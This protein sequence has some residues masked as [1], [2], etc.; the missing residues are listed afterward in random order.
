MAGVSERDYRRMLA[1]ATAAL[2]GLD[3]DAPWDGVRAALTDCF[4]GA[5]T[6]HLEGTPVV[7]GPAPLW[8]A[9]T[10]EE[11]P[12]GASV[13]VGVAGG[14]LAL[15]AVSGA[16]DWHRTRC[17]PQPCHLLIELPVTRASP[18]PP[19]ACAAP[20]PPGVPSSPQPPV[21]R[22]SLQ[23]PVIPASPQPPGVPSSPRPP[24]ARASLQLLGVLVTCRPDRPF[25]AADR[26]VARRLQP[27]LTSVQRHLAR[28]PPRLTEREL[29]VLA[30]TADG[31]TAVAAGRRL[32]ISPRTF[33][34]HLERLYRKFAT[35]DR[36]H[37]V[38]LAQDLGLLPGR[39]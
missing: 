29:A 2:G 18:Q 3:T 12:R 16:A 34:K 26:A 37:T 7:A 32:G 23:P 20:Q 31:L 35:R 1:V 28:R 19:V 17:G 10:H 8:T 14:A 36:V 25:D 11:L 38:L 4:R 39:R 6:L 15:G 27:L 9:G 33:E 24:G 5:A 22:A 13:R 21:A 30:A